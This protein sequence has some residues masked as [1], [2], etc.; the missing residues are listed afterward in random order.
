[1]GAG[2]GGDDAAALATV[3]GVLEPEGDDA[4]VLRRELV[5]DVLGIV[6][7]IVLTHAGVIAPDDEVGAA[8]VLA[9]DG[10]E[11]GLAGTRV[12]HG[13]GEHAQDDPLG[14]VV[15]PQDGLV[16]GDAHIGGDV[17]LLS[18][19]D[20]GV[21]EEAVHDLQRGLLDVL[22]GAVDGIAGLETHDGSPTPPGEHAPRLCR[23][24]AQFGELGLD[25]AGPVHQPDIAAQEYFSLPVEPGHAGVRLVGG[26]VDLAGLP[27]LDLPAVRVFLRHLHHGQDTL[28]PWP[29]LCRRPWPELCR[30]PWPELC[31]RLAE[32]HFLTLLDAVGQAFLHGQGDRDGPD[33]TVDQAHLRNTT[34]V[35]G[36]AHE[37]G[38]GTECAASQEFQVREAHPAQR[39][40]DH[41][42]GPLPHRF[43]H[44]AAQD[45]VH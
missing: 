11:D 33:Q 4:D 8:V 21:E 7:A 25:G 28:S 17:V 2:L 18:L 9:G 30:R 16:G 34:I 43:S 23:G 41:L 3:E 6:G 38:E 36:L 44:L 31:R 5:K 19:A 27:L 15:V 12:P 24:V 40:F 10:V 37:A 1:M 42:F 45:A 29:E 20:Q 13:G 39:D 26:L 35:V 22:V 32:G 14:G